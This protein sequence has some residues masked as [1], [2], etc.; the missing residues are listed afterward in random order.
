MSI[1]SDSF[2]TPPRSVG[3]KC[4][5]TDPFCRGYKKSC[6]S[7]YHLMRATRWPILLDKSECL[8]RL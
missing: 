7:L 2:P 6:F 4:I 3:A 1:A 8:L 5:L